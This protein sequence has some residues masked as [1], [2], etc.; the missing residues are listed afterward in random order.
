MEQR[1]INVFRRLG[2]M[3]ILW[4]VSIVL[5]YIVIAISFLIIPVYFIVTFKWKTGLEEL[6]LWFYNM[7]LSNDQHGGCVN[8]KTL[9]L[10]M[11]KRG[12]EKYGNP[13][14]TVSYILARN[15]HKS[16]NSNI[17][18]IIGKLLDKIEHNHLDKAIES[19]IESDQEAVL[20][21]Q[22]DK[23]YS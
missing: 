21:L 2:A 22:A 12:A 9:D 16:K 11:S 19:K 4:I 17:G 8:S 6:S 15:K 7:A 23:Y 5:K 3:I 20:R 10:F 14:D 1:K 13:D 18:V